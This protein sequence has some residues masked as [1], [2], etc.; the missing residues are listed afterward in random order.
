MLYLMEIGFWTGIV[1]V[2]LPMNHLSYSNSHFGIV[3]VTLPMNHLSYSNCYLTN[4]SFIIFKFS[5]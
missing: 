5:F 3:A 2:T 1:A 4:E